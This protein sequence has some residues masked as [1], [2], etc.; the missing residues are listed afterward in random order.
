M[1]LVFKF[2]LLHPKCDFAPIPLGLV[3]PPTYNT[4]SEN[5]KVNITYPLSKLVFL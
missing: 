2:T 1:K 4:A 3:P 5:S